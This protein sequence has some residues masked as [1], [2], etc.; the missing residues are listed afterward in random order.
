VESRDAQMLMAATGEKPEYRYAAVTGKE[1]PLFQLLKEEPEGSVNVAPAAIGSSAKNGTAS[2]NVEIANGNRFARLLRLRI[3][4]HDPAIQ[5][6]VV[7]YGENY[8]D[9]FPGEKKEI[10]VDVVMPEGFTGTASGTLILEGTNVS[11][12]RIPVSLAAGS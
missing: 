5:K 10:A 4:W 2:F 9:L 11:E 6:P 1:K 12:N 8:F 7:L 3:E